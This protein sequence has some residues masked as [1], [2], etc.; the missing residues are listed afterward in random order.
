MLRCKPSLQA[1]TGVS[2][3]FTHTSELIAAAGLCSRGPA[4][5]SGQCAQAAGR[6][7]A[8]AI[9]DHKPRIYETICKYEPPNHHMQALATL[10]TRPCSP[11]EG[12]GEGGAGA[13]LDTETGP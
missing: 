11:G 4:P 8:A 7:C 3:S 1:V 9:H 6:V 13:R 2:P 12:G 10:P 5:G